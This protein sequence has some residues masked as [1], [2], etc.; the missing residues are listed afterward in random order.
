M[1]PFFKSRTKVLGLIQQLP[2]L[3][4]AILDPQSHVLLFVKRPCT[5][6][7]FLLLGPSLV[8]FIVQRG[9]PILLIVLPYPAIHLPRFLLLPPV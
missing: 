3:C 1:V 8:M 6:I 4:M 2:L 5:R 9:I 7:I